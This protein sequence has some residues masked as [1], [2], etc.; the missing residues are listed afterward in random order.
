MLILNRNE[1]N[2]LQV[3]IVSGLT[4]LR[5]YYIHQIVYLK[6]FHFRFFEFHLYN[7]FFLSL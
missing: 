5:L 2:G 6:M 4:T 3:D 1:K 7:N